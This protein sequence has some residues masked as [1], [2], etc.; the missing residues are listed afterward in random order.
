MPMAGE[1]NLATVAKIAAYGVELAKR[2]YLKQTF[3][4]MRRT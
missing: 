1:I 2:G 4:P 3:M